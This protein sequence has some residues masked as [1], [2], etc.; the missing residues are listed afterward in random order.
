MTTLSRPNAAMTFFASKFIHFDN[1]IAHMHAQ[2]NRRCV[3]RD[4]R[5]CDDD[6]EVCK[7]GSCVCGKSTKFRTTKYED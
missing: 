3:N 5:E 6:N 7:F 4:N 1:I 2:F